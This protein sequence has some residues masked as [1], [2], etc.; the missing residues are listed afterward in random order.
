MENGKVVG[1]RTA[2]HQEYG[3]KAVIVTTGTASGEIIIEILK[4]SSDLIIV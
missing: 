3:A 2:T 1:V 4:Y